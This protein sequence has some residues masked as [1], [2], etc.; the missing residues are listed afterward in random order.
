MDDVRED[1]QADTDSH[2]W[3]VMA[4]A[5]CSRLEHVSPI[6]WDNIVLYGQYILDRSL[7][8]RAGRPLWPLP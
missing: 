7:V 6:K 1:R 8:R 5:C 4:A 2:A 3:V